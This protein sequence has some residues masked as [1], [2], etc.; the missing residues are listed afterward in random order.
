MT[1]LPLMSLPLM[2]LPLTSTR[3]SQPLCH[4]TGADAVSCLDAALTKG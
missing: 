1:P 3:H 2:S 4:L